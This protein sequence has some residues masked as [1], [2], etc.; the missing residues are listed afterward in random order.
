[1]KDLKPTRGRRYI[2]DLVAQGEHERQDFKFT[3][4]DAPKIARSISAFANNCGGQLLIG[5]KDNGTVAGVRNE[6]DIYVVEQAAQRYCDPPQEVEF[7][8]FSVDSGVVVIRARVNAATERPVC[9]IEPDGRR[10]AY[11]RVADENIVAHPLM[12]RAWRMS[13]EDTPA[14]VFTLG[15]DEQ[16]VI[17]AM[18]D[19]AGDT[20]SLSVKTHLSKRSV[21]G[22]I[23]HL[24]SI[25][26]VTFVFDGTAFHPQLAD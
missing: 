24:A 5:V 21:D 2:L 6:E 22:I 25:G 18:R 17:Q 23:A 14:N 12:V 3:I 13:R 7:A 26:L 16:R 4:G 1:M 11:Y 15:E 20:E 8:A 10:R 19:S 9:A